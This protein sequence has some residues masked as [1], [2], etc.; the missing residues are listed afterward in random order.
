MPPNT[1]NFSTLLRSLNDMIARLAFLGCL[2]TAFVLPVLG[3]EELASQPLT[4]H[5]AD[6]TVQHYT[7]LPAARVKLLFPDGNAILDREQVQNWKLPPLPLLKKVQL[8]KV[9]DMQRRFTITGA[10]YA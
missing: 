5:L 7:A 3:S 6:G 9:S 2:V 1:R 8:V 10:I 4:A